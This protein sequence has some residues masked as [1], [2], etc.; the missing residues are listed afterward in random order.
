MKRKTYNLL[1]ILL[2][3]GFNSYAN[4]AVYRSDAIGPN[5]NCIDANHG[6]N[7]LHAEL[8][9][10][11]LRAINNSDN[12]G[13]VASA[14]ALDGD[15]QNIVCIVQNWHAQANGPVNRMRFPEA[16]REAYEAGTAWTN[17]LTIRLRRDGV[18]TTCHVFNHTTN[19]NN[20][21][22]NFTS[23]DN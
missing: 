17:H 22:N 8:N 2:I 9:V 6:L 15:L 23:C 18:W 12:D 10:N 11:K 21:N 14:A 3:L 13:V 1:L 4:A 7:Q 16:V 20:N 5:N 19:I